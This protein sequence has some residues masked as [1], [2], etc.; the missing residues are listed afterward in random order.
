MTGS[1][2]TVVIG[3]RQY[4]WA[5]TDASVDGIG[6]WAHHGVV[7]LPNG[8]VIT[9]TASGRHL[10]TWGTT[11]L[12]SL[13][14]ISE[15]HGI[16]LDDP[17]VTNS[18]SLW[19]A[20]N[21]YKPVPTGVDDE[22]P[23]VTPGRAVR[24]DLD[25]RVLN[26]LTDGALPAELQGWRP[27]SIAADQDR[28]WVA[29]GYGKSAVHCFTRSGAVLWSKTGTDDG[30][31]FVQ[32]HAIV[33]DRRRS[34]PS[35]II[36]DRGNRRLVR[37]SLEGDD[38]CHFGDD[39]VTSPSGFAFDGST[40]WVTELYGGLVAFNDRDECVARYGD[41]SRSTDDDWPNQRVGG[42]LTRPTLEPGTF[43]SPHGIAVGND[44]T[45]YV[46]EWIIGGRLVTL[47]PTSG[48]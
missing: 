7:A 29:D 2:P 21:G 36:A 38:V 11:Q 6:G 27:T 17:A 14:D 5:E 3:G 41:R 10:V 46:T 23:L 37:L 42:V 34:E 33:V 32:P 28:V 19:I 9:A 39:V 30:M 48:T 16:A 45:L 44:G 40:L 13:L 22:P 31:S 18:S 47:T 4:L 20:D 43:R 1:D 26:E 12:S 35:L 24:L 25:G 8:T 15:C